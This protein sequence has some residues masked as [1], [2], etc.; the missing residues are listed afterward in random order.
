MR[1]T[2]FI[3]LVIISGFVIT[4]CDNKKDYLKT[5]DFKELQQMV[6]DKETFPLI[7]TQTGCSHCLS[8]KP[9]YKSFLEEY[10]ITSYELNLTNLTEEENSQLKSITGA[11]GTP[12]IVFIKDG[13]ETSALNRLVGEQSH[14]NLV[15]RFTNLEYIK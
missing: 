1:K 6:N 5:I 13:E 11:S 14:G 10:Q 3:M 15:S 8:F 12:N 7:L 4:G 2:L 9:V